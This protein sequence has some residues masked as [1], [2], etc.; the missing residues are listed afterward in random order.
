MQIIIQKELDDAIGC[1]LENKKLKDIDKCPI[2]NFDDEGDICV[3]NLCSYC[4]KKLNTS[5]GNKN[6]RRV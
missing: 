2:C 4:V 3:P 6:E 5:E 1:R